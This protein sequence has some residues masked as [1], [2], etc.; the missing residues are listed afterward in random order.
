M[1]VFFVYLILNDIANECVFAFDISCYIAFERA[2]VRAYDINKTKD[3]YLMVQHF[4]LS[5]KARTLSPIKIARLSDDEAF[6]M[7]CTFRW[8]S[9]KHVVCPKCG[10]QHQAYFISTRKQRR[11]KPCKHTFSITLGTIFANHK[12]PIQT[13]LFSIALFVNAVKGISACQLSRDLNVQYKTAF[14]LAHK[15]RESLIV[16]RQLFP[17]AGE[18]HIDGTYIHFALRP[19]NKKSERVDRRLKANINPN[20]RTVLVMCESYSE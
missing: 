12:L 16:Q 1:C 2:S 10:V 19:K 18:V 13:Y 14:T 7:L 4:L 20:K 11:C 3:S 9:E 6:S 15:I 17:L 5:S 8:G